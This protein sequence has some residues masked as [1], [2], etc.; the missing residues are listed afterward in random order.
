MACVLKFINRYDLT[1]LLRYIRPRNMY[2]YQEAFLHKSALKKVQ[3]HCDTYILKCN[4]RLEFLGDSVL[5]FITTDYLYEKFPHDNEGFLTKL[6]IKMVK[7]STLAMF[8]RKLGLHNYIVFSNNI[9]INNN[10]LEN[11]FEALVGA[12]YLDYKMINQEMYYVRKFLTGVFNDFIDWN[13]FYRDDNYKDILMRHTQKYHL[14][15]PEYVIENTSGKSNHPTF[16]VS[17]CIN[18]INN[19]NE[20]KCIH[21]ARC[22]REAEQ[23][24]ARDI[25]QQMQ[26]NNNQIT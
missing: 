19:N 24:C 22:K 17:L 9:V 13:D 11:T 6:R 18:D 2:Y 4:E 1:L 16:K 8:A 21:E 10:L 15:L 23:S 12:I 7:G 25:L 26:L 20:Y 14:P 5:N 3:K